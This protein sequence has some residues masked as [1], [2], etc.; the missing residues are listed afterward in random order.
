VSRRANV[1]DSVRDGKAFLQVFHALK[2][3]AEFPRACQRDRPV[4][5]GALPGRQGWVTSA[6]Q[7]DKEYRHE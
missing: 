6:P 2:P 4:S 3:S 5:H 1:V 7:H